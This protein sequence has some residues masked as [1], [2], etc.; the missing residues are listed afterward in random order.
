MKRLAMTLCALAL[1]V[2]LYAQL[3]A[4][5]KPIVPKPPVVQQ[6]HPQCG[7]RFQEKYHEKLNQKQRHYRDLYTMATAKADVDKDGRLDDIVMQSRSAIVP[8]SLKYDWRDKETVITIEYANGGQDRITSI[9]GL[10]TEFDLVP[11]ER[12]AVLRGVNY[13]GKEWTKEVQYDDV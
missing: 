12:R 10:T 11:S 1:A 3:G 9:G 7:S 8:C 4:D 5:N 13:E 2:P 6:Y